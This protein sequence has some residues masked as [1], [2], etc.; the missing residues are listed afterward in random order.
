MKS[1]LIAIA[2]VLVMAV[3]A[4]AGGFLELD[5]S[6]QR[7]I[8][9]FAPNGSLGQTLTV[10]SVTVDM[11]GSLAYGLYAPSTGCKVRS[12]ATSAKGTNL[13]RTVLDSQWTVRVVNR[14][15][16]FVNFSGCTSGELAIQ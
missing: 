9:G 14:A 13:Q 4:M 8:Q 2:A 10:N 1:V 5:A 7:D 6:N 3:T 16:P 11:T 15:T 12:M